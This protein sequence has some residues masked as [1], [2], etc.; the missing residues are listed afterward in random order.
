METQHRSYTRVWDDFLCNRNIILLSISFILIHAIFVILHNF[1]P[2]FLIALTYEDGWLEN[3]SA[4]MY[5]AASLLFAATFWYGSNLKN[6]LWAVAFSLG[7]FI[8]AG[9]EASWGQR[10]LGYRVEAVEAINRQGEF[11]LHNLPFLHGDTWNT[12]RLLTVASLLFGVF[13]PLLLSA[14][15]TVRRVLIGKFHFPAPHPVIGVCF[16]LSWLWYKLYHPTSNIP[17]GV[18]ESRETTIALGMFVYA[19][20]IWRSKWHLSTS[21]ET[22]P[23]R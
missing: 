9:E 13:L 20:L 2:E 15:A 1:A 14:S 17:M 22:Q 21:F 8:L 12:T 6:R 19:V 11:N 4:L 10:F 7:F 3:T 16:M 5:L 18:E 23:P